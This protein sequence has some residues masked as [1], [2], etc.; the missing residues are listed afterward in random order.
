MTEEVRASSGDDGIDDDIVALALAAEPDAPVPEDAV[1]LWSLLSS[2]TSSGDG[3]L[4]S[5][6][7][8]APMGGAGPLT[9][10]RRRLALLLVVAL[11]LITAYGL[12]NTY[13]QVATG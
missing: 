8:P 10:W 1:D 12:C 4:P 3:L 6:Y 5:W 11:L 2:E 13:G 7:M 9:G